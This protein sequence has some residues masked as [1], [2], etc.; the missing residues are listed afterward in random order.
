[1]QFKIKTLKSI[2]TVLALL[3]TGVLLAQTETEK[4]DGVAVVVGKNIVLDSD[5]EKFKKEVELRSEGKISYSDCEMLEELMQQK[6]LAHHAVIDSVTVS[7]SEIDNNVNRSLAFFKNEYGSEEKVIAA[8]GFNDIEDLKKELAR[9]QKEN[10]LIEKEQKK[11]TEKVD[12]TPEE[13]R[14]YFN[15]LKEKNELPEIPAEV[16]LQQLVLKAEPTE[17]AS[18]KVIDKLN[19]IKKEVEE[20]GASFKLKAIINSEDPSVSQNSGR[21][22]IT[23]DTGFAK[24]FKE[25]SFSLD[26]GQ[27]SEPFKTIFGYHII[28]LHKIRGKSREVSHILL[29]PEVSDEKLNKTKEELEKLVKEIK[30][31]TISFE[32]A[33]RKHSEDEETKNSGGL[34][35]N[36][37]TGET[38]WELTRMPPDLF[39][40]ISELKKDDLSDIFYDETR[41]GQKMYKIIFLKD[42]TETHKADLVKDYVRMQQ[43]ALTKKKEETITKWSKEKIQ[44]TYIKLGDEYKKCTFK[45][46]WKKEN[47]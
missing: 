17:E 46:D 21:Y 41:G 44:E 43:F 11:I 2:N 30:E 35:V 7:Q 34:L 12:V 23:K 9:V 1:M 16:E 45:K 31:G 33:V 4:I 39:G 15:G 29:Q 13:V 25:V 38:T 24:E 18:Q 47:K 19:K 40:R 32:E 8:Y 42:K 10:L 36:P 28:M 6:L 37:Y 14:V 3:F 5:I 22:V 26:E 20:D 27:I